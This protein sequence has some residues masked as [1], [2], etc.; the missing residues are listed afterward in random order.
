MGMEGNIKGRKERRRTVIT[1][2]IILLKFVF[3]WRSKTII[4]EAFLLNQN[5]HF[6]Q[7]SCDCEA[8]GGIPWSIIWSD[9]TIFF[10]KV[11]S[12]GWVN[13]TV[14]TTVCK[15]SAVKLGQKPV[16]VECVDCSTLLL[17]PYWR[18]MVSYQRESMVWGIAVNQRL[19]TSIGCMNVVYSM[20]ESKKSVGIHTQRFWESWWRNQSQSLWLHQPI[21]G[22]SLV[23]KNEGELTLQ[24][25]EDWQ[26]NVAQRM[27]EMGYHEDGFETINLEQ[28]SV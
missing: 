16:L 28:F 3:L 7:L 20:A 10:S 17:S 2:I 12:R 26:E 13:E 21:D 27:Y 19:A 22:K 8:L 15:L 4:F 5:L 18:A 14:Q 24:I 1:I 11:Q 25:H 6:H 23:W 9:Y